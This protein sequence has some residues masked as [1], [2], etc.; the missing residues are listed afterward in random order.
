MK[1]TGA[2]QVFTS[3]WNALGG[4]VSH[5]R[6]I[7]FPIDRLALINASCDK[8]NRIVVHSPDLAVVLKSNAK[9][10]R[11]SLLVFHTTPVDAA[12][13]QTR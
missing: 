5:Y 8:P 13:G 11:K 6:R 9:V 2:S 12:S 10:P 7:T 3:A 4:G 1:A